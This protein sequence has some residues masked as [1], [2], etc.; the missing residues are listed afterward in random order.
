M[1]NSIA[2]KGINPV[3]CA[4]QYANWFYSVIYYK[5]KCHLFAMFTLIETFKY[6]IFIICWKTLLD[7]FIIRVFLLSAQWINRYVNLFLVCCWF[8]WRASVLE[9]RCWL[10]ISM[11]QKAKFKHTKL[12]TVHGW[13]FDKHN[14]AL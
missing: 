9:L 2:N 8:C 3:I 6:S 10:F 1:C 7:F 11:S 14:A 4:D 12:S 13:L 5:L